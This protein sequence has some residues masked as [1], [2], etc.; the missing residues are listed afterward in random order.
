[1]KKKMSGFKK[2]PKVPLKKTNE[3]LGCSHLYQRTTRLDNST[4]K[5]C[6]W[7]KS[8]NAFFCSQHIQKIYIWKCAGC[9]YKSQCCTYHFKDSQI[10]YLNDMLHSLVCPYKEIVVLN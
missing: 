3:C 5:D 4:Q 7:C 10:Q 9:S 1:M 2:M 6:N 8:S